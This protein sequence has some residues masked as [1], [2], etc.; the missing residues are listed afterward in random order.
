MTYL[1]Q[2]ALLIRE[3]LDELS[4]FVKV[5]M[6]HELRR[7]R[8][9]Q[10]SRHSALVYYWHLPSSRSV[11]GSDYVFRQDTTGVRKQNSI[12]WYDEAYEH[13]SSEWH[14]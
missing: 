8:E 4:I 13:G 11:R 6:R 2:L 9:T 3:A 1:S 5:D 10:S 12:I 14:R 7:R